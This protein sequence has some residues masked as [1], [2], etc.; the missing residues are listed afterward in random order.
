MRKTHGEVK[1][2]NGKRVASPEYRTWQMMKNRC[3]N[4]NAS[5]YAYYGERGI[6]VCD[7]W[8]LFELFLKDMGRRP[9][10]WHTL[11]RIN[12]DGHYTPDN[13]QWATREAQSRNRPFCKLTLECADIIRMLYDTGHFFQYELA[14]V[15][16]LTQAHISQIT[17]NTCWKGGAQ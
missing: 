11:D 4:P 5:D 7:D 12:P 10:K 8:H 9:T 15:Y 17:R 13:C 6:M 3:H 16:G 2:I 14:E 1:Q